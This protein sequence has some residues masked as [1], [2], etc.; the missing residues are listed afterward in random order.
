MKIILHILVKDLR[1]QWIELSLFVL[2]C[3][4]WVWQSAH[5]MAW[6]WFRQREFV[7]VLLFGLWFFIVIHAVQGECLVGDR[8]FWMT[9]PY[10]WPQLM[11]AKA[12]FLALCLNFPLFIAQI[13]LLASAKIPLSWSLLPGLLF[14]GL[15]FAFFLT[16]PVA[17]LAATTQSV[18]Q[19]GL[20]LAGMLVYALML[21]WLPWNKLPDGLEGGENLCSSL[22]MA[23]IAPALAFILLW[24]YARRRV[25]PP[26]LVFAGILLVIPL[27]VL[28]SSAPFIRSITYPL[29]KVSPPLRLSITE[30]NE[31]PTRTYTRS[32]G[33]INAEISIPVSSLPADSDTIVNVDGL[34]VT[35][36]AENGWRWQSLWQNRSVRFS[37]N[38]PNG[39][40]TFHMPEEQANQMAKLHA[41]VSVE[42]AFTV[43]RLGAPHRVDTQADRFQL[44]SNTYCHWYQRVLPYSNGIVINGVDCEAALHLPPIIEIEIES[45]SG[46]CSQPPGEPLIPA[47]HFASNVEYGTDLP[48]D[49]DPN[50][51]HHVNLN[52]GTWIPPIPSPRDPRF[53]LPAQPCRGMPLEVRTGVFENRSRATYDLGFIGSE[54][55]PGPG[56]EFGLAP[57]SE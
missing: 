55:Q 44:L 5:P 48:A 27:I 19:W 45:G 3:A 16:F 23:I 46:A 53:N 24:Q 49:F 47:G 4:A 9:R 35:L 15:M 40:L 10:R 6:E 17:A 43:Y 31:N 56:P 20:A 30:N 34:R 14:L 33:F 38:S 54:K 8:E 50:P 29:A 36:T 18:V 21:S 57:Y 26:R 28:L 42:L 25:W 32:G 37:K 51:A 1:R 12:L 13:F 52:F 22:G 2:V 11:V 39:S 41:K 7:P